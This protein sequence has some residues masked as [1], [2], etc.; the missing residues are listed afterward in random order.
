MGDALAPASCEV[1][2]QTVFLEQE[3]DLLHERRSHAGRRETAAGT[4]ELGQ[5]TLGITDLDDRER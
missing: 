5:A 1:L 3:G 4:D 2:P